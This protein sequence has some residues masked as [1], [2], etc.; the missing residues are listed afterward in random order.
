MDEIERFA[1]DLAREHAGRLIDLHLQDAGMTPS[2]F[3]RLVR[4]VRS[5][6]ETIVLR[7]ASTLDRCLE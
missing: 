7:Y 6:D 4:E 1:E 3:Q 5:R 2:D